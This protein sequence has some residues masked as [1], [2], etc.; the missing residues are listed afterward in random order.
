MHAP[1]LNLDHNGSCQRVKA[2]HL[3]L[4]V[5]RCKKSL[6]VYITLISHSQFDSGDLFVAE[7]GAS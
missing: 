1:V 4:P 5:S 2:D 6:M 3:E 7:G